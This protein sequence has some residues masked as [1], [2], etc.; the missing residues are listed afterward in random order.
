[1]GVDV[2]MAAVPAP[3]YCDGK[4]DHPLSD[5]GAEVLRRRIRTVPAHI[6]QA[7]GITQGNFD[8]DVE[9]AHTWTYSL[10]ED[11]INESLIL[12]TGC[13]L[14][15][16][17][18][19]WLVGGGMD[20]GDGLG[21]SERIA[22]LALTGITELPLDAGPRRVA[23]TLKHARAIVR[24]PELNDQVVNIA[25]ELL[26]K[27]DC[28]PHGLLSVTQSVRDLVEERGH[29]LADLLALTLRSRWVTF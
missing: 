18:R 6:V 17:K 10:L 11:A 3:H 1:M 15:T 29:V 28:S 8:L 9:E 12:G 5:V 7:T 2:W 14:V 25:C 27:L 16:A 23:P 4:F 13:A 24:R 21:W 19:V 20:P 22:A 26:R